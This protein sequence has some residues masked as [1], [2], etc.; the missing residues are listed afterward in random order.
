MLD[1]V[2]FSI[3]TPELKPWAKFLWYLE[4][5]SD[6][7][8]NNKLLPTD[9][10]DLVLNMSGPITYQVG[11]QK[12]NA[13]DLHF[14]GLHNRYGFIQ[15]RGK[16]KVFGISFYPF[17]LYP[18]IQVPLYQFKNQLADLKTASESLYQ[19]LLLAL[20]QERKVDEVIDS[21]ETIL[22][23]SLNLSE[24][25]EEA[26]PFLQAFY[27]DCRTMTIRDFCVENQIG[28]K[29]FERACLK[30]TGYGPK[31]LQRLARFQEAS[32][33]LIYA[34][35]DSSLTDLAYANDYYDQAHFIKDFRG[36]AGASPSQFKKE[37]NAIKQNTKYTYE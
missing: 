17:G 10:I 13:P 12:I 24:I 6:V 3:Q 9:S 36:F 26:L 19:K 34:L 32:N 2:R 8:I 30:Y 33:H 35:Q 18:F 11:N 23:S 1:I 14:N 37:H 27:C 20:N 29:A 25:D 28:M 22:H 15:Q 31:T 7:T 4:T 21:I 16:L 5:N